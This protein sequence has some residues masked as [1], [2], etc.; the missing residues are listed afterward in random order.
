MQDLFVFVTAAVLWQP[1]VVSQLPAI[2]LS[3]FLAFIIAV[4]VWLALGSL[5]AT[6]LTRKNYLAPDSP[7]A[8]HSSNIIRNMGPRSVSPQMVLSF[9]GPIL[10]LVA[11][12]LPR[13][14]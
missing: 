11:A 13:R 7:Q 3:A 6:L 8:V 14:S 2:D 9:L 1:P 5:G 12:V 10:L 4:I